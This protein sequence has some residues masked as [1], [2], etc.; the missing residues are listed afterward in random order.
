MHVLDFLSATLRQN[1]PLATAC[2]FRM[3]RTDRTDERR[4]L[5]LR[6]LLFMEGAQ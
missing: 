3:L 2:F 1:N 6:I 5:L 4:I